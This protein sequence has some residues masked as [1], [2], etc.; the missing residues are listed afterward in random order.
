MLEIVHYLCKRGESIST[1]RS[2]GYLLVEIGEQRFNAHRAMVGSGTTQPG[3]GKKCDAW[4]LQHV[5]V[6][7]TQPRD[8]VEERA[9]IEQTYTQVIMWSGIDNGLCQHI[10]KVPGNAP[11]VVLRL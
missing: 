5:R 9:R 2:P 4:C 7:L 3:T 6:D 1:W 11:N 10:R 8:R